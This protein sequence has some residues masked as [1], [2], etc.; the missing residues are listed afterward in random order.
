M[1]AGSCSDKSPVP[2]F[3]RRLLMMMVTA[4]FVWLQAAYAQRLSCP[5]GPVIDQTMSSSPEAMMVRRG[6]TGAQSEVALLCSSPPSLQVYSPNDS[7]GLRFVASVALSGQRTVFIP[8]SAGPDGGRRYLCADP[9]TGDLSVAA[10]SGGK[11]SEIVVHLPVRG[12]RVISADLDRDG[13]PD[14]LLFG[15]ERGG[16]SVVRG[17][18]GETYGSSTELFADISVAD[19]LVDDINGDGI[20]DII[21]TNW[22]SNSLSVY[23]GI[24]NLV[25]S[26]QIT[27]D[28]PGEPGRLAL[29]WLKRR[30]YLELAVTLPDRHAVAVVRGT[31]DGEFVLRGMLEM[32]GSPRDV[33]YADVDGD[34]IVDVAG[35][36]DQ[37]VFYSRGTVSGAYDAPRLLGLGAH[38]GSWW[39]GD[40]DGDRLS[41]FLLLDKQEHRISMLESSRDSLTRCRTTEFA[42]G[43]KPHGVALCDANADGLLDIAVANRGSNSISLLINQGHGFFSGEW[44]A[45]VPD[46]PLHIVGALEKGIPGNTVVTSHAGTD[47]IEVIQ[48]NPG[49]DATS[50]ALPSG[51]HPFAL[52][53]WMN[54][55]RILILTRQSEGD[56]QSISLFER[57][58]G[59]KFIEHNLRARMDEKP[60]A[61]AVQRSERG[62]GWTLFFVTGEAKS[63]AA[64][65]ST[66]DSDSLLTIGPF[67][68]RLSVPDSARA[69]RWVYTVS[70]GSG[71]PSDL[72][73]TYGRPV[74]ALGIIY[75]VTDTF[76]VRSPVMVRD[77]ALE[78]EDDLKIQDV[79]GDGLPDIVV[80]NQMTENFEV[81]VR[82]KDLFAGPV[83]QIHLPGAKSFTLGPVLGPGGVDL[84]VTNPGRGTVTVVARPWEGI[85]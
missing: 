76:A 68:P 16:V 1:H 75:A 14:L 10:F 58:G 52:N 63:K 7:C 53:A 22:L 85:R 39:V 30:R 82:R 55:S 5:F 49:S 2:Q 73:L 28:L 24:S 21:L 81:Y 72:L 77:V 37:G 26:E 23:Y 57:I 78:D 32:D 38:A 48:W 17:R 9:L 40:L 64:L 36:S 61:V 62:T 47:K 27:V 19:M 69:L 83:G 74:N 65:I 70:G 8:S 56:Q 18:G 13:R 45:A 59:R 41:E 25:F 79:N 60:L 15:K 66:A 4:R 34:G 6:G 71:G 20:P 35:V 29:T 42:V 80:H 43:S 31:P 51:P 44:N 12:S 33:A 11:S 67:R 50:F 54:D 84:I 3:T 46:Q